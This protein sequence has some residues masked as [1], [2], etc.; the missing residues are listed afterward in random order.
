MRTLPVKPEHQAELRYLLGEIEHLQKMKAPQKDF[1]R[2]M[3]RMARRHLELYPE[4]M[5]ERVSFE[6]D[7]K[8]KELTQIVYDSPEEWLQAM[9]DMATETKKA[10]YVAIAA[11]PDAKTYDVM[12]PK[13]E[14]DA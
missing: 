7:E 9:K 3:R 8:T 4:L 13:L 2:A 10:P 1:A 14:P 5:G 6:E 12:G 11:D